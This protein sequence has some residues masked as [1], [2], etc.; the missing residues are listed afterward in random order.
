ML[1][2]FFLSPFSL[3]LTSHRFL[4]SLQVFTLHFLTVSLFIIFFTVS[5]SDSSLSPPP[6][7]CISGSCL[8]PL[9]PL[10]H[11]LISRQT[12]NFYLP[13]SFPF[14]Y[15]LC[16]FF[17]WFNFFPLLVSRPLVCLLVPLLTIFLPCKLF[18]STSLTVSVFITFFILPSSD[19]TSFHFLCLGLLFV[20]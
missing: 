13:Y 8:S 3:S 18:T 16:P 11:P 17:I 5:P 2:S 19:S 9:S 20:S 4:P 15:I 10:R 12:V 14:P 6:F 7:F 1:D